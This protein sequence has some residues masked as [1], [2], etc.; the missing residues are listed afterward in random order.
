MPNAYTT[1]DAVVIATCHKLGDMGLRKYATLLAHAQTWLLTYYNPESGQT[2]KTVLL[3]VGPDHVAGLP[4]D[5]LDWVVVGRQVGAYVRTLG[6]NPKLSPLPAVDPALNRVPLTTPPLTTWPCYT[7]TGWD[8]PPLCGYGWGE[9]REEFTVDLTER[10]LHLSSLVGTGGPLF[11]QYVSADVCPNKAT[12][13]HP[14]YAEAL[15]YWMLWH[16]HLRK[17]E[18]GPANTYERLYAAAS[19]RASRMLSPFS[20]ASLQA[21]IRASYNIVR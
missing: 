2:L 21:I 15:E 5:Y 4:D 8:G 10:T 14:Y 13:L 17:N 6:H 20:L 18:M 7:Y 9:Y 3:D 12:P 19:R 1:V 16:F 11:F